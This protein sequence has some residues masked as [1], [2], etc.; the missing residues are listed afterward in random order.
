M[1]GFAIDRDLFG[2]AAVG[3]ILT[4][5]CLWPAWRF[6][7]RSPQNLVKQ[8]FLGRRIPVIGGLAM[9]PAGL[10]SASLLAAQAFQAHDPV[11]LAQAQVFALAFASYGLLGL[12]DDIFGDRSTGGFRGHIGKLI[13]ERR[14][15]TGLIKLV[16]GGIVALAAAY[17]ITVQQTGTGGLALEIVRVA[18]YGALIALSAN[19]LNLVDLRPGRCLTLAAVI[20]GVVVAVS[21][22]SGA[23]PSAGDF[24]CA[25]LGCV[26][27]LAP[28]DRSGRIMLGDT[29]SNA[30]GAGMAV[31]AACLL[32]IWQAAILTAVMAGFQ[33]WCEKHSLTSFIES[34]RLLRSIDRKIGIR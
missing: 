31:C 29:G 2:Y 16:G 3:A 18:V 9:L 19:T 7:I 6:A 15:T 34:K 5:L 23:S 32:S 21:I 1:P 27:V 10:L 25:L 24:A 20:L 14:I 26:L 17:E 33:I 4:G 13:T 22:D 12:L 11:S 28:F 30:I 8:N